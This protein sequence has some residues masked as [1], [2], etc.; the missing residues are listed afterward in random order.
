MTEE[1]EM[2][3]L[4]NLDAELSLSTGPISTA[5]GGKQV[6]LTRKIAVIQALEGYS[7][8]ETGDKFKVFDLGI[9][10]EHANGQISI[11]TKESELVRAAVMAG[12]DQPGLSVPLSRW[13]EGA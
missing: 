3:E 8:A 6:I 2:I 12:W 13:L 1:T 11:T 4:K 7:G 9:R 10:F 5:S